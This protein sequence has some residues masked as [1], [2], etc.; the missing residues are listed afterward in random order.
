MVGCLVG[1]READL[2][3]D[4]ELLQGCWALQESSLRKHEELSLR[5]MVEPALGSMLFLQA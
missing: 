3:E 2:I 5:V 4:D 1:L